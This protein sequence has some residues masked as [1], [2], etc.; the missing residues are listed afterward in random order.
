MAKLSLNEMLA[1]RPLRFGEA[2]TTGWDYFD[3]APGQPNLFLLSRFKQLLVKEHGLEAGFA[4]Y[5]QT[6]AKQNGA[7]LK[8]RPLESH[9]AYS[10]GRAANF[11]ELISAGRRYAILP[12]RVIGEGNHRPLRGVSRSFYLSCLEDGIVRGRSSI[13][14][15][16]DAA[17][18]D[19]Q[20]DELA[21]IDDDVEFD[22]AIFRRE[23]DKVWVIDLP[24][25]ALEFDEALSLLGCR[26][27]FFGDWMSDSIQRYV[28]ATLDGQ[29]AATTILIDAHI[30]KTHRQALELMLTGNPR[31]VEIEAFQPVRVRRLWWPPSLAY[32]PFHQIL[33]ELFKWDYLGCIPRDFAPLQNEMIRRADLVDAPTNGP[34][35]VFLARKNFRHRKLVNHTEIEAIAASFGFAIVYTEELDFAAQARLLRRA[36]YVVAPEG[37]SLFLCVF[38]GRRA[39][40]CILNHQQTEGVVLYGGSA[41]PD[42]DREIELTIITGPEAGEQHGRSQ[43]MNYVIDPEVFCDFLVEWFGPKAEEPAF[44]PLP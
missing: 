24:Q 4:L 1:E 30:P 19:F 41:G 15:M 38:M 22:G 31:I 32:V 34:T 18:A 37:S 16:A 7:S 35:R 6:I 11:R 3:Y 42:Y 26:T 25:P 21:R 20:S 33:N 27:D 28:A 29:L 23:G 9:H 2:S 12:P 39:K 5:R 44:T 14:E 43:D 10:K 8:L 17:L 36:R 13:V 40:L